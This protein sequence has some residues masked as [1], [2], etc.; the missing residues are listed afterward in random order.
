MLQLRQSLRPLWLS[1]TSILKWRRKLRGRRCTRVSIRT[2]ARRIIRTSLEGAFRTRHRYPLVRTQLRVQA[3]RGPQVALPLRSHR[4]PVPIPLR[5]GRTRLGRLAQLE[6]RLRHK[7]RTAATAIF[8]FPRPARALVPGGLQ[9]G[10]QRLRR[11]FC[12]RPQ[13]GLCIQAAR[14]RP[15]SA[16]ARRGPLEI[17]GAL[18]LRLNIHTGS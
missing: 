12:M 13:Q 6:Q 18:P 16:R 8:P 11:Q 9:T 5:V 10:K 14:R 1:S 7:R 15:R 3:H 2:S 17:R 4:R